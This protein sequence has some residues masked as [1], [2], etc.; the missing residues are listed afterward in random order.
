MTRGAGALAACVACCLC[1]S[2]V[3]S[4]QQVEALDSALRAVVE[5]DEAR[6]SELF[7]RYRCRSIFL[8]V[9]SNVGSTVRKLYEPEKHPKMSS[10]L[11]QLFARSFTND[12][13]RTCSIVFEYGHT[14]ARAHGH[15]PKAR[16][17]L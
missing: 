2:A 14:N 8:D 6:I 10:V 7:R 13:C 9:G 3:A 4:E 15:C 1:A 5:M 11:R 12:I 17:R 16:I